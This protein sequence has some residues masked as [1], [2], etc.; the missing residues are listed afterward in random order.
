MGDGQALQDEVDGGSRADGRHIRDAHEIQIQERDEGVL[1][2]LRKSEYGQTGS[3]VAL[4]TR[5]AVASG[6][7]EVGPSQPR[8]KRKKAKQYRTMIDG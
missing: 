7:G 6:G 4:K 3:W 8:K 2:P 1:V 5:P